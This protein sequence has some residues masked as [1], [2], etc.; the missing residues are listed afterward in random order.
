MEDNL[1]YGTIIDHQADG[2]VLVRWDLV[3]REGWLD[4]LLA[5]S[6][7]TLTHPEGGVSHFKWQFTEVLFA[8]R[9]RCLHSV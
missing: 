8:F 9:N 4:A 1:F 2:L 7:L 6:E 5:P 3:N